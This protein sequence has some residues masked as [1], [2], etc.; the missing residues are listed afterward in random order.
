MIKK[1]CLQLLKARSSKHKQK[2]SAGFTL[3]ELLVAMLIA[4]AIVGTLLTFLV[5]VLETDRKEQAKSESQEEIQAALDYI[6]DDMQEAIY[7]YDADGLNA[8]FA[9]GSLPTPPLGATN[10]KGTPVLVFWKRHLYSR[11]ENIKLNPASATSPT[12][13]VK[14]L[15]GKKS[16]TFIEG[17]DQY[18]YSL[19]A[20]YL[21]K[22]DTPSTNWSNTSRIARWEIRD[23]IT[24]RVCDPSADA[25]S[26][27]ATTPEQTR[28]G[29]STRYYV[30]PSPG[31]TRFDTSGAGTLSQ[32]MNKWTKHTDSY[33]YTVSDFTP[34]IDFVD[35]T[36]YAAIQDDGTL[37]NSA[38]EVTVRPNTPA[39][40]PVPSLNDIG[41]YSCNNA[42]HGV[43]N[44]NPFID[45]INP[46]G[47][48]TQRIPY[49]FSS[50]AGNP[51]GLSSFYACVNPSQVTAR[52]Y[53]RGNAL[54]RIQPN[55]IF[56]EP[57]PNNS[58]FFPTANVRVNGRG[59]LINTNN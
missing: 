36:S 10:T 4:T 18:V 44:I 27:V 40:P 43:G 5:S 38:I 57:V 2:R 1:F 52:V 55:R 19:V 24:N 6:A 17:G 58:Q 41:E 23:G 45:G 26:C 39:V 28:T 20:Y 33:N 8:L 59:S 30:L 13:P 22:D 31:F 16:G 11:D 25:G 3:L 54:A 21:L 47:Q 15:L 29:D 9:N 51:T 48:V 42:T 56:R 37:G 35:D 53:I 50:A 34:L 46:T 32:K 12:V 14:N 7:I 49:D